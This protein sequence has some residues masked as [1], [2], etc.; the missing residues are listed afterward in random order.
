MNFYNILKITLYALYLGLFLGFS[1]IEDS[2]ISFVEFIIK[3]YVGSF[4]IYKFN[5]FVSKNTLTTFEKRLIYICGLYLLST[6]IPYDEIK[7]NIMVK[8]G[9]IK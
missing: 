7:E 1:F 8:M 5:P 9:L 6:I 2:Y 4:I 3:F